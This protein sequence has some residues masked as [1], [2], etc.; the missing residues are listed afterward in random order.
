MYI[1]FINMLSLANEY[2]KDHLF[3]MKRKIIMKT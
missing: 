1:N 3:E 2:I